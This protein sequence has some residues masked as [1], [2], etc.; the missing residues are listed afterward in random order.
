MHDRRESHHEDRP[1]Y[2][3]CIGAARER[4]PSLDHKSYVHAFTGRIVSRPFQI[5]RAGIIRF[6]LSRPWKETPRNRRG[7]QNK[8]GGG[9]GPGRASESSTS[10]T[11][12]VTFGCSRAPGCRI[13]RR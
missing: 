5:Q 7:G 8:H 10:F 1:S 6:L 4:E 13:D 3:R 2:R 11:N 9:P 12:V